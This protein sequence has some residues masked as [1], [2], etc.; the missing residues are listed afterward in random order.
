MT[1][2]KINRKLLIQAADLIIEALGEDSMRS[3]LINTPY[4]FAKFFEEAF[5]GMCYTNAE[6]AD[7]CNVTFMDEYCEV[8]DLVQE[9]FTDMVI[10]RDIDIFSHCEHHI[11]LMYDMTVSVAYLPTGRVIGL[12]KVARI[13]D[14]V[15]K[16][17]QIQERI[18][19]DIADIITLIT[20]SDDVAVVIKG[21]H[22]CMT[23]R[24]I[25]KINSSTV[26]STLRGRFMNM[27]ELR[28]EVMTLLGGKE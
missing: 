24:G 19:K 5:E 28:Q 26:T 16:R 22:A 17:L 10:V 2:K 25:K 11:A 27:P 4:R 14:L 8:D 18:G 23:A 13:A 6:I 7:M 20:G 9:G 15:S 3:G 1:Q 12:S 21:K